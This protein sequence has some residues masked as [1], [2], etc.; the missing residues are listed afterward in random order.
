MLILGEV[1]Y[2]EC[3]AGLGIEPTGIEPPAWQ[4]FE[5]MLKQMMLIT[6]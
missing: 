1:R 4:N 5:N 3:P 6:D 2:T